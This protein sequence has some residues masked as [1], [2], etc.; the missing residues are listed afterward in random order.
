MSEEDA[1]ISKAVEKELEMAQGKEDEAS[2]VDL[3]E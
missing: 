1:E 3:V 2:L